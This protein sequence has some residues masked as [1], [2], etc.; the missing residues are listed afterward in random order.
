MDRRTRSAL[1][2]ASCALLAAPVHAATPKPDRYASPHFSIE[3][4]K[5]WQVVLSRPEP[6]Q[7]IDS[8]LE[9]AVA[10][11]ARTKDG[12]YLVVWFGCPAT[13]V[14]SDEMWDLE[15]DE[16]GR[17]VKSITRAVTCTSE[18]KKACIEEAGEDEALAAECHYCGV[19]DGAFDA[20]ARFNGKSPFAAAAVC[21]Q[22]GNS[23][24]EDVDQSAFRH[25]LST[26]RI[27]GKTGVSEPKLPGWND[28]RAQPAGDLST[29]P[30]ALQAATRAYPMAVW[31]TEELQVGDFTYDGT[32]DM[33]LLGIEGNAIFVVVVEG[34]VT[35]RSRVLAARLTSGTKAR[36]SLCGHPD[37]SRL[38]TE[39]TAAGCAVEREGSD[40]PE[41]AE[42]GNKLPSA[43]SRKDAKG[44]TLGSR[45]CHTFHVFFDGR[46]LTWWRRDG[47]T[48]PAVGPG[49]QPAK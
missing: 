5:G 19:G 42:I 2:A 32:S 41:C 14:T 15:P 49:D 40:R 6:I 3:L 24:R 33:A 29:F 36:D 45:D 26:L 13:E 1:V 48:H 21:F 34:P 47:A 8:G 4:A 25:M 7:Q 30:A 38:E 20:W 35:E 10:M 22:F 27:E 46:A 37:R 43:A 44:L 31:R 28:R 16:S 9:G 11:E 12:G 18:W 39:P 17:T 23:A